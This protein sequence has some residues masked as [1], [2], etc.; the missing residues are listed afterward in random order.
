MADGKLIFQLLAEAS[1][2]LD[3]GCGPSGG[4]WWPSVRQNARVTAIDKFWVIKSLPPNFSYHKIA[5]EKI[6]KQAKWADSF[7]LIVADHLFEHVEDPVLVAKGCYYGAKSGGK[8][9]VGIPDATFFTDRFY[10]LIHPE[11]GGHIQQLTLKSMC[12]IMEDAGFKTSVYEPW[13]DDWLWLKKL[14]DFKGRGVKHISQ[15]EINYL[16]D[17]FLKDLTP[18]KGYLYGWEIIFQK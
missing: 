11:G 4:H 14:Y 3:V 15:D 9:H 6:I 18:D 13:A 5:A 7:D 10:R 8:V 1:N 12:Q 16:A 17:V 2:I